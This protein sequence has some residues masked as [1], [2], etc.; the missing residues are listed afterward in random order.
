MEEF[1]DPADLLDANLGL[2][3]GEFTPNGF[4][5]LTEAALTPTVTVKDINGNESQLL[6]TSLTIRIDFIL[7]SASVLPL[8]KRLAVAVY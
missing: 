1:N 2:Y 6:R 7:R 5:F 4:E 3:R 8:V